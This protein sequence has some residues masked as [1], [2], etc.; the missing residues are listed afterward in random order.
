ML[1]C[2]KHLFSL[3]K[4]I[5]YLNGAYMS[6]LAI[7]VESAGYQGIIGKKYP[8]E[9]KPID[10]FDPIDEVRKLYAE[11]VNAPHFKQIAMLPSVSYG[12]AT[13]AKNIHLEKGQKIVL[14]QEQF[15]SNVYT[16]QRLAVESGAKIETITAPKKVENRAKKWND[17]ILRSIDKKTKVVAMPMVH[18]ADG[19][20]FD[21]EKIGRRCR[22]VGAYLIIDGTQS[23][24]ALPFDIQKIKPDALI[25]GGYK[26]LMGPY[27]SAIGYFGERF[28]EGTPIE[29]SWMYR[30]DSHIFSN[31]VNYQSEYQPHAVRYNVGQASNFILLPMMRAAFEMLL[32]FGVANIQKYCKKTFKEGIQ[33]LEKMGAQIENEKYR[34]SH[35]FGVRTGKAFKIKKLQEQFEKRKV[36]VS[37]RGNSIRVSPNVYND[38]KDMEVL[39]KCFKKAKR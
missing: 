34:S 36:F 10:F 20:L 11:L 2:Q 31:L 27:S 39:L 22:A 21:L 32:D 7:D 16:W 1:K 17:K 13:V 30:K 26:W 12:M 38:E 23:V 35:L 14:L 4:D 5:T 6:P 15:P 9:I 3:P 24:G 33:E 37:I 19:T 8:H 25:C 18:W 28:N 29:E